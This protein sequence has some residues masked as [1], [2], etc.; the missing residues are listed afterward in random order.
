[1]NKVVGEEVEV[2]EK[3]DMLKGVKDLNNSVWKAFGGNCFSVNL[4]ARRQ[5]ALRV[6]SPCAI[7]S[8]ASP[9]QSFGQGS[10]KYRTK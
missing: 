10:E 1:M 9:F 4:E 3:K 6:P 8:C 5:R 2:K 7:E